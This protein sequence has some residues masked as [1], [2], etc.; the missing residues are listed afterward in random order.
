MISL[1]RAILFILSFVTNDSVYKHD[2]I[3]VSISVTEAV[4]HHNSVIVSLLSL[5][6]T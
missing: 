4:Y 3:N 2:E 5:N 1:F 6:T